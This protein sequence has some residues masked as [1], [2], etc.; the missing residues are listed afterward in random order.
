[1][2]FFDDEPDEPTRVTRPA[3]PRRPAP[4][5]GGTAAAPRPDVVAKRRIG[6][7]AVLA[8]VALLLIFLFKSCASSRHKT[9]L[10]NYNRDVAS[11]IQSSDDQV[12][13]QLFDVLGG[14]GQAA[15]V[16]VAVQQVR[17][18]AEEDAKRARA[19]S[20]PGDTETKAAQRDLELALDLRAEGVR[21]IADQITKALS[22]QPSAVA[23]INTITGQM[24]AF[25]ASDVIYSQRV[26]PLIRQALDR[27]GIG[28]QT[29]AGS[30]FLPSIGWLDPGQVGDKLNPD[31]GV[32][33]G[34]KAGQP[35]P[36]THGHG[37]VS[38]T[39]GS[40]T[41][42]PGTIVNRVPATA[43]LPVDVTFAN[44]GQNDE[45]NVTVSVKVTGGPKN[46]SV[47]KRLNQTK[48]GTNATVTLQLSTVPPRGTS[49]TMTVAVAPV[50]G[51]KKTDNNTQHYTI[52]FTG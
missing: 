25:L 11:V 20:P 5:G 41:L 7:F 13:K 15:D 45:T 48:A 50:P 21:K 1:M 14:G 46:I 47:K 52:L 2:S 43:P 31:A 37:L 49:A 28:D 42:Q 40:V 36:G 17:I 26:A 16:Q 22:N 34:A 19:L 44:Q 39:A 9:A 12:S 4:R 38:V 29:I 51:E 24:Q 3:R 27:N 18:V 35:R 33:S 32:S 8:V 6:F 23:A 10:K 30:K